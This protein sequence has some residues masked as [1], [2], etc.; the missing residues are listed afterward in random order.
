MYKVV[1]TLYALATETR[2][3]AFEVRT[4]VVYDKRCQAARKVRTTCYPSGGN[5][6]RNSAPALDPTPHH[7]FIA[8][9]DAMAAVELPAVALPV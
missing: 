5:Q 4:S 7:T 2:S 3:H 8:C 1:D 6:D 9:S